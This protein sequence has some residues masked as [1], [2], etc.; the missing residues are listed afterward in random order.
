MSLPVGSQVLVTKSSFFGGYR[1]GDRG[2]VVEVVK[3]TAGD[4]RYYLCELTRPGKPELL[5]LHESEIKPRLA[6]P[7]V[8][9][10][11]HVCVN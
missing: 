2:R 3:L 1:A 4:G 7:P 11:R 8:Q 6:R 9:W 5:I 10:L